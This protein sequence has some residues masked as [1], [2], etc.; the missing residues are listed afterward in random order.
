MIC[1]PKEVAQRGSLRREGGEVMSVGTP[2]TLGGAYTD[3]K[4]ELRNVTHGAVVVGPCPAFPARHGGETTT[5]G[6]YSPPVCDECLSS[7]HQRAPER[8]QSDRA[9][10]ESSGVEGP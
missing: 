2:E 9:E 4:R 8:V 7:A 5:G 10:I 3:A 6:E 1:G